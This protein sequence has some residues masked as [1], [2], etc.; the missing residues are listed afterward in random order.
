M[1]F[2]RMVL[3]PI[4]G[5]FESSRLPKD[6]ELLLALSIPKPMESHVHCFCAFGLNFVGDNAFGAGI[7]RLHGSWWLFV[8]KFF[9]DDPNIDS[10]FC[11]DVKSCKFGFGGGRH[12]VFDDVRNVENGTIVGWSNS[13]DIDSTTSRYEY[14]CYISI[15]KSLRSFINVTL[16]LTHNSVSE[17]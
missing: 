12:D 13:D 2:C 8:S 4:V 1:M 11:H 5:I 6:S 14:K 10:F 3:G 15:H 7:V 9:K 16:K 17:V